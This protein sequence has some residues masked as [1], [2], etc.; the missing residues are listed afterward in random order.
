MPDGIS[1][2]P[3]FV[4]STG[5]R[6]ACH[7]AN[8]SAAPTADH[9]AD[10][11]AGSCT[12]GAFSDVGLRVGGSLVLHGAVW[13]RIVSPSTTSRSKRNAT[14]ALPLTR[15]ESAASVTDPRICV[16]TGSAVTPEMVTSFAMDALIGSSTLLLF[17][18]NE[19]RSVTLAI[20]RRESSLRGT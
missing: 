3:P 16:P 7:G 9:T 17:D 19:V 5:A 11:G 20:Y 1:I 10:D 12:E 13:T 2:S 15:P 6:S 14:D 18:A 8:G 4:A